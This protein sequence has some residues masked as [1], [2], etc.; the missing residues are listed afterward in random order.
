MGGGI[1]IA[2]R[3]AQGP[4]LPILNLRSLPLALKAQGAA[5]KYFVESE[6]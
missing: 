6:K 3:K 4:H 2:K 5:E 1:A